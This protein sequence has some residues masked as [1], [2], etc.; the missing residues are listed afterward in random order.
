VQAGSGLAFALFLALHLL[1]TLLAPL[2]PATYDALQVNLRAIYQQPIIEF[3]LVFLSL[4]LHLVCGSI[5]ARRRAKRTRWP[6]IRWQRRAG[7]VLALLV[8]GHTLAT[9]GAS[10]VY[11]VWPGFEGIAF[12]LHWIPGYFYP[13]YL[14]FGL[15]AAYHGGLGLLSAARVLG[16]R[17]P[18]MSARRGWIAL[19]GFALLLLAALLA[20]GGVLFP[21]E[22]PMTSAYAHLYTGDEE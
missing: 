18:Q 8:I 13:Y 15:A 11:G 7:W 16:W 2:G 19:T 1:N 9:R 4:L 20:F 17:P 10:L 22:D 12:S 5:R 6:R 21:L 14:L 3:G